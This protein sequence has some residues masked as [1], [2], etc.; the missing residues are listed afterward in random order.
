VELEQYAFLVSDVVFCPVELGMDL[1]QLL[2]QVGC[3]ACN[4]VG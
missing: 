3:S 2:F 1:I 4:T